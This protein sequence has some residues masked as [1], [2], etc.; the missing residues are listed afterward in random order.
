MKKPF[1]PLRC[2][3]DVSKETG[4]MAICNMHTNYYPRPGLWLVDVDVTQSDEIFYG[5]IIEIFEKRKGYEFIR[6]VRGL[7]KV[8][9]LTDI[10]LKTLLFRFHAD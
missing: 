2:I 3:I 8:E 7:G 5:V 1:V 10:D 6:I 4:Y 9:T